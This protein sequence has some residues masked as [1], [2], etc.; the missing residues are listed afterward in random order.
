MKT[1]ERGIKKISKEKADKKAEEAKRIE[2]LK[3]AGKWKSKKQ[4]KEEAVRAAKR[5]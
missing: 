3:A 5:K 2:D 4:L 1:I